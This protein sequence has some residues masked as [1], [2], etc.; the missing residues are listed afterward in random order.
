MD[1][2]Q[3]SVFST[4]NLADPDEAIVDLLTAAMQL[5]G[6]YARGISSLNW[7]LKAAAQ[8]DTS[9]WSDMADV[10]S[11]YFSL[12]ADPSLSL[13][14]GKKSYKWGKGYAWNPVGFINRSKDPNNPEE[15]LEGYITAETDFIKSYQGPLQ[16][17]ALTLAVLP[18]WEDI[19]EDFG[20]SDNVNLAAKLYLLYLDTDI[21]L[22]FLGGDSR[23]DRFGLDFSTNLAPHF[24]IHGEAAYIPELEK[25]I[26]EEDNSSSRVEDPAFSTLLGIRYLSANDITTIVEYYYNGGGYSQEEM[27][28][29]Y[30]LAA[31]G[32]AQDPVLD[33]TLLDKAREMSLKGYGR[34]QPGRQYLYSKWTMKEPFDILYFTPGITALVNLEDQSY[35]ISPEGVYN[36]LTNW[37]FRLRFSLINGG[38]A[39]EYGEKGNSNK[40]ELRIRY[41]F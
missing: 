19:N 28:R 32:L 40:V 10:Y 9:G 16:T 14:L 41:F 24:E 7:Q 6:S 1:L 22:I 15:A 18:V 21:D 20:V 38:K 17:A 34:P 25:I 23:S 30:Q 36:G 27:S 35:S 31:A 37:E 13:A 8:E 29:F 33:T 12:K 11:A 5:D 39:T 3:G 2:N 26:L 4:L